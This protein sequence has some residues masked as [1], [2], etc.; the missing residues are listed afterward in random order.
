MELT[1]SS[2]SILFRKL[3]PQMASYASFFL[4]DDEVD[5]VVQ[6]AFIGLWHHLDAVADERHAVSTLHRSIYHN[7]LNIIK[8][9]NIVN[10]YAAISQK[11]ALKKMSYYQAEMDEISVEIEN[12]EL[13]DQIYDAIDR[14]PDKMRQV[15]VMSYM[16]DMKNKEIAHIMG[17]SVRTVEAHLY[18]ALKML[19]EYL[20]YLIFYILIFND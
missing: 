11:L 20:G 16:H 8:H 4:N 13:H 15:F 7:A 14:L 3:Y 19:R 1:E 6:D 9:R 18:K 12:R 17:I 10:N 2:F 5:D